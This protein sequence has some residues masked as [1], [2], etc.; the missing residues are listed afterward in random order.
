MTITFEIEGL[1]DLQK[2]LSSLVS[3][4]KE[5]QLTQGAAM[6]ALGDMYKEV[7]KQA[8]VAEQSYFRYYRGSAKARRQG[9]P[10][11]SKRHVA[12]GTLRKSIA[13][14]RVKLENSV[15]V[16]IY[17]KNKAFY[18]RFLEYGTPKM[19]AKP[20]LRQ[21][22]ETT[23]EQSVARFKERYKKYIDQIIKKQGVSQNASD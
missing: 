19:T 10:E 20:F 14:K 17:V 23:K 5:K 18:W 22:F 9:S 8:P 1:D 12:P 2:Q 21:P 16:G 15:G 13:R 7:R 6:F 11:S 3:L 4:A